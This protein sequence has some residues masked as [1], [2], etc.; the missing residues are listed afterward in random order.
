MTAEDIARAHQ[1]R[2]GFTLVDYAEVGLPIFRL[3]I[4]AFT[5]SQRSIPA[6]QEFTMRCLALGE[7]HEGDI[8]RMLGL[9][10]GIIQGAMNVMVGDGLAS[11]MAPPSDLESFRLSEVGEQRLAQ[12]REEVVH[13]EMLVI[14]YDAIRRAPI[15]LAGENVV[16][17]AELKGFGAVEIR[18]YPSDPPTVME[19]SIPEVSRA[20]RRQGGIDFHRTVLALKRIVRRNNVFRDA[21]ALV[22]AADKG[23][24]VQVAFA[25]NGILSVSH[26]RAFAW[27]G[28][29]K[30]MG[31]VRMIADDPPRRR[32]DRLL[33]HDLLRECVAEDQVRTAREK[34][35]AA[36]TEVHVARPA[37]EMSR[38]RATEA[39]QALASAEERLA[40]ARH[41]LMRMPLRPLVCY[42]QDE[43]LAEA[44]GNV[45]DHLLMTS[46]GLQPTVL[47]GYML[48]DLD[49]LIAHGV[50]V[51]ISTFL[52]LQQEPRGGEHYDPL[53][54][55]TRRATQGRMQ[56]AKIARSEFFFLVQDDRLG[57]IST[58][59]FLGDVVRRSG[60]SRVDGYVARDP[61]I[62]QRIREIAVQSSAPRKRG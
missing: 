48:R 57:V 51:Q 2:E 1:F 18:P 19:L 55:L 9:N 24:E 17:A 50:K 28:G 58:R 31:F 12:E 13:E 52:Q 61:R 56:L 3:T 40:L 15:R 30:K 46:A 49:K 54:E 53:A 43:L 23:D 35:A 38:G 27:N 4:E 41:E 60:F 16:R 44:I 25:I 6:I 5:T 59:P 7:S 22:F 26:E 14:D 20:I 39:R 36:L 8:A 34:E 33:G 42:E 11:R 45:G 32:L 29:P 37:V 62:V 10:L 47:N 21:V